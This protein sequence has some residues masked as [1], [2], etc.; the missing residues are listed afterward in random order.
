VALKTRPDRRQERRL[1]T[2]YND[3]G[4]VDAR[5]QLIQR[6]LP[7]AR[8]L[9][10]RYSRSGESVD[11]LVQVASIGLIKA[12]DRFDPSRGTAFSSFAVPSILGELKRHFRDHGWAAHVPRAVQERALKV[13]AAV[14]KLTARHGRSPTP[15][16]VA[17]ASG[18]SVEEVLEAQQATCSFE[19]SSLDSAP[20]HADGEAGLSYME[21]IGALDE[22][23]EL[24]EYRSA[25]DSAMRAMPKREL[26]VLTLRF[27]HDMTQ[28]E[29][30]AQIGIS[31]MH[32][33][34]LIRRALDRLRVVAEADR[35][36]IP[37]CA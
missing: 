1:F 32:V 6:C 22:H 14:D 3:E 13:N 17:R 8:H 7:L 25:I 19:S 9:A 27:D 18:F 2:R 33:S 20:A 15:K 35:N 29:I 28:S 12:V 11:D 34:R 30:A 31:Q 16:E 36:G 10:G 21:T 24:V 26:L 5:D 23:F 4:D 37:K